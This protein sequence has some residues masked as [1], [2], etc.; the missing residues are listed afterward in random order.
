MSPRTVRKTGFQ[1]SSCAMSAEIAW[2]A[3][4]DIIA[5]VLSRRPV[6]HTRNWYPDGHP[7]AVRARI[8]HGQTPDD[9]LNE[10]IEHGVM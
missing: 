4:A 1:C 5:A 3:N 9:L 8:P 6:P 2:P 7:V 10:N